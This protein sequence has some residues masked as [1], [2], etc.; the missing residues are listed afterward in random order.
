MTDRRKHARQP[1]REQ[2]RTASGGKP[3]IKP[4]R[5]NPVVPEW[6]HGSKD[7]TKGKRDKK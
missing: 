1:N 3:P 6:R 7:V 4:A 5:P 2:S